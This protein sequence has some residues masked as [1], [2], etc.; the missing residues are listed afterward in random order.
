MIKIIISFFLAIISPFITI[1]DSSSDYSSISSNSSNSFYR[2]RNEGWHWYENKKKVKP[3]KD[4]IAT[5][6]TPTEQIQQLKEELDQR[7]HQAIITPTE[8]NIISYITLQKQ[9]MDQSERFSENWQKVLYYHP[10]LDERTIFPVSNNARHIYLAEERKAK[11][12]AIRGL[13][14]EYGLFFFFRSNCP[15]CHSMSTL[16]K[17]FSQKYH[18]NVLA[19]SLDGKALPEF[20]NAKQD[21]GIGAN[22]KVTAVPALFAVHPI[23]KAIIPLAQG[24]I[25]E[26]EIEDRVLLLMKGNK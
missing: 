4:E 24:M 25:S 21:N 18:W 5:T 23:T 13:A 2:K 15:Y 20:P 19:V 14:K 3:N 8:Q 9:I 7:L 11:Q 12:E 1:A 6:Q 22:L 17:D 16:I 26:T 10:D